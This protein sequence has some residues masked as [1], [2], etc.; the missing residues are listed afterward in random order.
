[1]IICRVFVIK[2]GRR[3]LDRVLRRYADANIRN[4]YDDLPST[5]RYRIV[6]FTTKDL[7][8]SRGASAI[9]LENICSKIIPTFPS[10][11]IE[12]VVLHPF[13][14][15]SF[16]WDEIPACVKDFAEMSFYGLVDEDT[17]GIYG[18]SEE[19]GALVVVRPDGY[20]GLAK[21]L[22][23]AELV[24]RYFRGCLVQVSQTHSNN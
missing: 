13:R 16:E 12:L 2:P 14:E 5:G 20:V 23:E 8:Q 10:D 22:E 1:M 19:Q 17:Y 18:I 21:M 6:V 15:R 3:I 11:T 9:A 7:T 24:R 4:L